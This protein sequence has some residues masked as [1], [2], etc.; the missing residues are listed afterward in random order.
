GRDVADADAALPAGVQVHDVN[1]GGGDGDVLQVRAGEDDVAVEDGLVGDGNGGVG[2]ARRRRFVGHAVVAY[3]GAE[4]V[5]PGPWLAAGL[6]GEE[7]IKKN[8][9]HG[10]YLGL[11]R[12]GDRSMPDAQDSCRATS[13]SNSVT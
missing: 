6:V 12:G 9:L 2:E 4:L 1:A 7:C 3:D 5:E 8:D 10:Q 13:R 11:G